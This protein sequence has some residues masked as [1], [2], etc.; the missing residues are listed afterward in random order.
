MEDIL[1]MIL[2]FGGGLSLA[3]AIVYINRTARNRETMALIEK[4]FTPEEIA[5]AMNR[6][7]KNNPLSS[8]LLF[9]G[10]GMGLIIGYF[11]SAYTHI[12]HTLAYLSGA[13]IFGG[14]GLII[15]YFINE[16][17]KTKEQG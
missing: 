14:L 11:L 13:F 8:A 4:G 1:G 9:V 6:K 16:K 12:N 5:K 17:N 15:A 7:R 2:V 10:A 3:F